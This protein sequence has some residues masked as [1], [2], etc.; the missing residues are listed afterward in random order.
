MSI[1]P[2][3]T[4][5]TQVNDPDGWEAINNLYKTNPTAGTIFTEM[6]K[7]MDSSNGLIVSMAALGARV[8]KTRQTVAKAVRFLA[9]NKYISIYKSGNSNVYT[10]NANIVWKDK[11]YKKVEAELYC[12]VLLNLAEQSAEVQKGAKQLTLIK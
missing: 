9:D 1:K 12:N 6:V 5:F 4:N 3:F 7:L 8:S 2:K 10:L 11:G